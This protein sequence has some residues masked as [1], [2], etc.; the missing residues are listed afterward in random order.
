MLITEVCLENYTY[1]PQAIKNGAKRIELCDNLAVG[2]TTVS[3]GV[4]AEASRYAHEK[5][6]PL[7]VMIR[8]RG[9]NFVYN[10]LELRMMEADLFEAQQLGADGVV[11][12]CLT[13]DKQL[14]EEAMEMLIGA[15]GGMEITFHMAFDEIPITKQHET[16]DWLSEH[17][18]SRILTHGG[19]LAT[20]IT[21]NYKQLKDTIAYAANRLTVLPGGGI[22]QDNLATI[23]TA[24]GVNEAH[25]SKIVGELH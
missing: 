16:I 2:G 24:L 3:K 4:M 21:A 13:K 22:T 20:P 15:A 19:P 10:D 8:P 25:G 1:L 17:Q 12:G 14:D 11:F 9:G 5:N 6:I 7:F 23:S 18:V